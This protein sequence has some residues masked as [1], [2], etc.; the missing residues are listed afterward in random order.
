MRQQFKFSQL[1]TFKLLWIV[2]GGDESGHVDAI[3]RLFF[4]TEYKQ[5]F[6]FVPRFANF[7]MGA[8]E[9]ASVRLLDACK[10]KCLFITVIV[11]LPLQASGRHGAGHL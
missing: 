1:V 9:C 7:A 11:C 10:Y 2:Y 3:L 8:C 4:H 6:M 5:P